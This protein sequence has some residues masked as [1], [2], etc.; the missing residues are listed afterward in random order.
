MFVLQIWIRNY[1]KK[2]VHQSC[3]LANDSQNRR[4]D[5]APSRWRCDWPSKSGYAYHRTGKTRCCYP[6]R[7]KF[8]LYREKVAR[9]RYS[10]DEASVTATE[11]AIMACATAQG[12]SV[13]RNAASE[14]HIQELCHFLNILGAKIENIGSIRF[15][16]K[17]STPY[18]GASLHRP[19]LSGSDQFCRCSRAYERLSYGLKMPVFNTWI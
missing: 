8:S 17:A 3:W 7:Q 16:L 1:V 18:T 9:R 12:A 4:V 10:L 5:P 2:F 11:N 13:I 14:P 19:G 6:I 15:I